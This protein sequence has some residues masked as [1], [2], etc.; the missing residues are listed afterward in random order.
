MPSDTP[1]VLIALVPQPVV[2]QNL[3]IKVVCLKGR[4]MNMHLWAF[5]EKEAVVVDLDVATVQ[6]EEDGDILAGI[7][8]DELPRGIS[9][10]F[11]V[12]VIRPQ[13]SLG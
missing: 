2:T 5:E 10:A 4:V 9:Q 11:W 1:T 7:V 6:S 3:S 8:M 13:T 12:R